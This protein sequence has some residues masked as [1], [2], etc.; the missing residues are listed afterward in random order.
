MG[1]KS[2]L[3]HA[4][5]L[6]KPGQ[7]DALGEGNGNVGILGRVKIAEPYTERALGTAEGLVEAPLVNRIAKR[8]PENVVVWFGPRSSITWFRISTFREVSRTTRA[9]AEVLGAD[10]LYNERE[11]STKRVLAARSSDRTRRATASEGRSPM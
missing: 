5:L 3:H 8:I 11:R 6:R 7:I 10:A 2:T 4:R 1:S 9:A